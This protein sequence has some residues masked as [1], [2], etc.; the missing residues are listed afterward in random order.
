MSGLLVQRRHLS[1]TVV[2]ALVLGAATTTGIAYGGPWVAA[3]VAALGVLLFDA[4]FGDWVLPV[5]LAA[6]VWWWREVGDPLAALAETGPLWGITV[7]AGCIVHCL[8]DAV[9]KS[10]CPFLFPLRIR[11]EA[12]YEIGPPQ[13]LRF[14]TG[15]PVEKRL[16]FPVTALATAAALIYPFAFS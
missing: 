8:G 6:G 4:V 16:V 2:F 7:A 5:A 15:G 12:W 14:R 11:G 3:A 13:R 9:T 10:G 1:H